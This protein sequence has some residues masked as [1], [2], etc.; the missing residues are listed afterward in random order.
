MVANYVAEEQEI[1]KETDPRIVQ[2]AGS[3]LFNS[4]GFPN[5][6]LTQKN[7]GYYLDSQQ[8]NRATLYMRTIGKI[9]AETAEILKDALR[10]LD[11]ANTGTQGAGG[12]VSGLLHGLYCALNARKILPQ[13]EADRPVYTLEIGPGSGW[14]T[15]FLTRFGFH[16]TTVD[17]NPNLIAT[18]R[19]LMGQLP[20]ECAA[21]YS[22][23]S[24][25]KFYDITCEP[26]HSYDMMLANH[27]ICE[28]SQWSRLYI[29][30]WAS[31]YL[32]ESGVMFFQAWGSEDFYSRYDAIYALN[33]HNMEL[34]SRTRGSKIL[35][36]FFR[37]KEELP[38]IN[39]FRKTPPNRTG[40]LHTFMTRIKRRLLRLMPWTG[41]AWIAK[42]E[43]YHMVTG[44]SVE[45]II[46][47]RGYTDA[48][49]TNPSFLWAKICH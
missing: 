36:S 38:E 46:R 44:T 37:N 12:G 26:Q 4:N 17:S 21:H 20:P 8:E 11:K 48:A 10:I 47:E 41:A 3:R 7:L 22:Q 33:A 27:M 2:L 14:T 40:P 15:Y 34:F 24:W 49:F 18:Q 39:F 5:A 1:Y 28:I 9:D 25:W 19:Y 23:L 35:G 30:K 29:A 32:K 45:Q 16:T 43:V 42:L 31:L 6:C 13:P